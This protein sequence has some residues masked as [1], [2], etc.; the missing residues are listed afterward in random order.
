MKKISKIADKRIRTAGYTACALLDI[1]SPHTLH[2]S[3]KFTDQEGQPSISYPDDG[4]SRLTIKAPNGKET[5]FKKVLSDFGHKSGFKA[6]AWLE[7]DEKGNNKGG[8]SK[9]HLIITFP[10]FK[11]G[12]ARDVKSALI[13]GTGEQNPQT[14]CVE[15]FLKRLV[16][17]LEKKGV[18]NLEKVDILSHSLGT[19]SGVETLRRV[20]LYKN[21]RTS[22]KINTD[23]VIHLKLDPFAAD[24]A[25]INQSALMSNEADN[26]QTASAEKLWKHT[27]EIRPKLPSFVHF[28]PDGI[29]KVNEPVKPFA[30][31]VYHI[32]TGHKKSDKS[33]YSQQAVSQYWERHT[34]PVL[35][36]SLMNPK[37]KIAEEIGNQLSAGQLIEQKPLPF[38]TRLYDAVETA[39]LTFIPTV[40]YRYNEARKADTI[41]LSQIKDEFGIEL[42]PLD[43]LTL[44]AKTSLHAAN[45]TFANIKDNYISED[46]STKELRRLVLGTKVQEAM[47]KPKKTA[48]KDIVEK[49]ISEQRKGHTTTIDN[50]RTQTNNKSPSL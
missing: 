25:V 8:T 45:S 14:A 4:E 7:T 47:S 13:T 41:T 40:K 2:S 46:E 37:L 18:N 35:G 39:T 6:V 24:R 22:L 23:N 17:Q 31:K 48:I 5:H 38:H 1:D 26:R 42:S 11:E 43:E 15:P 49:T 12:S 27:I 32:D 50:E 9:N 3:T 30:R 16:H 44:Q 10:G 29:N 34:L 28:F 36:A 21:D 20:L 33:P 19:Q